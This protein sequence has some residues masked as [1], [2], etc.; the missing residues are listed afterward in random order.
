VGLRCLERV[1]P[2]K[3]QYA[4]VGDS[5]V[6]YR[7]AGEG[8]IDL[9]CGMGAGT[10]EGWWEHPLAAHFADG[11]AAFA[12]LIMF[13]PRGTGASDRPAPDRLPTWEEWTEDLHV[14]LDA[15]GSE[16]TAIFTAGY[17]STL[18]MIFAATYPERLT[19]LILFNS[20]AKWVA[21]D[22]YPWGFATEQVRRELSTWVEQ[23]WGTEEFVAAIM[24]SVAK[25][26]RFKAWM[27]KMLRGSAS[28]GMVTAVFASM[29]AFDARDLL[30]LIQA[31]TLILHRAESQIIPV[32]HG[33]YL[34]EHIPNG[35]LVEVPGADEIP[36]TEATDEIL[37]H[38]EEFLTGVRRIPE[39]DRVLATVLFTDI[40]GSTKRAAQMG[41]AL[42]RA[43][44]DEHDVLARQE[45]ER[46]RGRAVK[47]TGDGV[48][49]TFD[50]PAR[51]IRCALAIREALASIGIE[52]RT[53]LHTG[54]IELR[55]EDVGGIAV[56]IA[57]RVMAHAGAGEILVSGSVPPLVAGSGIEFD[58]RGTHE[59]K[60]IPGTWGLFEVRN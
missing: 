51:A 47:S 37:G 56:H 28:P 17:A 31:P 41:D 14:V 59:L 50:G 30:P 4:K 60:G 53:G 38:I 35:K 26:E 45:I 3:T 58:D 52:V 27:A 29:F 55:N 36:F 24:P 20:A 9:V 1:K 10:V 22:G 39:P 32:Q 57:A 7:V 8:P 15:V 48:L 49:A 16:R 34:A 23:M 12:R 44:L 6:A 33:Q 21:G 43:L 13:D 25:D 11:L 42:W 46:F 19:A 40:V 54:E 2:P 18:A 5:F